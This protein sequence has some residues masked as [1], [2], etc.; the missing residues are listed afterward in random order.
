MSLFK[1][2]IDD[3]LNERIIF[4]GIFGIGKSYFL[5]KFFE[6]NTDKY[7]AVNLAPIN[8]SISNNDDI[9]RLIKYDIIYELI[10]T[11]KLELEQEVISR[12]IAYGTVFSNKAHSLLEGL[13]STAPLLNKALGGSNELPDPAPLVNFLKK[14]TPE[15]EKIEKQRKDPNLH[16]RVLEFIRD[17]EKTPVFESDFV[18]GFI[19]ESLDKLAPPDNQKKKK[20]LII[21]DLDRI[22]PEHIFRL[23]NIFSSHLSYKRS[24]GNKF[25]F[26]KVIFVCDIENIRNIFSAR[27]GASVDFSGYIDKFYN[28]EIFHFDNIEEVAAVTSQIIESINFGKHNL[29]I[30]ESLSTEN[31]L[32]L[33]G[34]LLKHFIYS[35]S[36][37]LRR[38]KSIY[39]RDYTFT[40]KYIVIKGAKGSIPNWN[41]PAAIALELLVWIFGDTS[42]LEKALTKITLYENS[43]EQEALRDTRKR[44]RIAGY[45][46]TITDAPIHNF[47]NKMSNGNGSS[48]SEYEFKLGGKNISYDL[49][50]WGRR[51]DEYYAE[52]KPKSDIESSIISNNVFK[53][54][55]DALKTLQASAYFGR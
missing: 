18:T 43:R 19:T 29:F 3:N 5:E 41:V 49:I 32:G 22:D 55:N 17:L 31:E 28:T 33:L 25:G 12:H 46:V 52:I 44:I 47:E 50:R 42:S 35:G 8:Y 40:E 34:F 36:L 13:L 7:L 9:F 39:N 6:K 54:I 38:L 37:N 53:I 23:F 4:S 51:R 21:D 24:A 10:L 11:H 30:R 20:V 1:R 16:E 2:H 48:G 26:D 14:I 15:I 45:F 27:Y